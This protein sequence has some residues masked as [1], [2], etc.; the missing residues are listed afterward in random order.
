M[1]YHAQL[2]YKGGSDI[3]KCGVQNDFH[4]VIVFVHGDDYKIGDAMLTPGHVVAKREVIVVTF[5]Y[6]LGALG[7]MFLYVECIY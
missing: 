5:N 1:Y 2:T 7:S 6:R 3:R 4:P